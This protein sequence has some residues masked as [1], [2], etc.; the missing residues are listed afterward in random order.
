M[1]TKTLQSFE[2]G[3]DLLFLFSVEKPILSLED[4][5]RE[6]DLPES[7]ACRLAVT[8]CKK[9]VF[10]ERIGAC[11]RVVYMGCDPGKVAARDWLSRR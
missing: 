5:S 4:I 6:L 8:L 2:R 1:P 11:S 10:L 9:S 3:I 7:T